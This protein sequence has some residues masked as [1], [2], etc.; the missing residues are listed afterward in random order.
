[1]KHLFVYFICGIVIYLLSTKPVERIF[2]SETLS[3]VL[4][5]IVGILF[6]TAVGV[7]LW[8]GKKTGQGGIN[9]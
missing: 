5:W 7:A 2:L 9:E 1:M 6:V 4:Y 3:V 8:L